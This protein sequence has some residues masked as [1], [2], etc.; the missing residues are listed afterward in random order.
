MLQNNNCALA[1]NYDRM[2]VNYEKPNMSSAAI[3]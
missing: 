1:V 3:R 2:N